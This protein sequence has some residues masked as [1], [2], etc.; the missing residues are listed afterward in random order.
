[1]GPLQ[2]VE[3]ITPVQ[4]WLAVLALPI[5]LAASYLSGI[6][7]GL[8]RLRSL[9]IMQSVGPIAGLTLVLALTISNNI[10]ITAVLAIS[11]ATA[12]LTV[13][14]VWRVIRPSL[15]RLRLSWSDLRASAKYSFK[16]YLGGLAGY[17]NYRVDLLLLGS[18]AGAAAVGVYSIGVTVAELMWYVPNAL[19]GALLAK[20]VGDADGS[21]EYT[22]RTS[23]ISTLI[24]VT[25]LVAGVVLMRPFIIILYGEQFLGAYYAFLLL[26]P[27][28]LALGIAKIHTAYLGA[29]GRLYP[30]ISVSAAALNILGNL[31]LIPRY[32]YL[33]SAVAS[34]VSYTLSAAIHT[35]LF[36]KHSHLSLRSVLLPQAADLTDLVTVGRGYLSAAAQKVRARSRR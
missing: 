21:A 25:S 30:A 12:A 17:L 9:A 27:G 4:M 20:A 3:G 15:G 7:T 22:A 16:A 35:Y 2:L 1:M 14:L 11:V 23:R 19:S 6:A 33:G 5:T 8:G 13:W 32:G 34:T 31:V 29:H 36:L 24:M 10:A 26:A 18:M 28:V